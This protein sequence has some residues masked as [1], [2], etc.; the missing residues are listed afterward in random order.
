MYEFVVATDPK[1]LDQATPRSVELR[2][3]KSDVE[4]LLAAHWAKAKAAMTEAEWSG[5]R[6]GS[7]SYR[8]NWE[9]KKGGFVEAYRPVWA[10]LI[11]AAC[12]H[13]RTFLI[14]LSTV[15]VADRGD[16]YL[17]QS[18]LYT[19]P[20]VEFTEPMG[21][22]PVE[23]YEIHDTLIQR[24]VDARLEDVRLATATWNPVDQFPVIGNK[25]RLTI[26]AS[27]DGAPAPDWCITNQEF[28]LANGKLHPDMLVQ[29][30]VGKAVGVSFPFECVL[31]PI[32][33]DFAG[34]KYEAIVT[35]VQV[36]ARED[37]ADPLLAKARGFD[38]FDEYVASIRSTVVA[39]MTENRENTRQHLAIH[40]LRSRA[41]YEPLPVIWI[42]T[43]ATRQWELVVN[44][45]RPKTETQVIEEQHLGSREAAIAR[46][47]QDIGDEFRDNLA[48]VS[49]GI[50]VGATDFALSFDDN[51][52]AV[53]AKMM[54]RV[55]VK[56]VVPLSAR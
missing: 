34:K 38:T 47:A 33:R 16:K 37:L 17:L 48:V 50:A 1:L 29:A 55:V 21:D 6:I 26:Q 25:V 51:V 11:D 52:V 5:F 20:K 54:D 22:I 9:K 8:P 35:I 7:D 30:I 36:F 44:S 24:T 10:H 53:R 45:L 2:L 49:W 14:H 12:R 39:E 23:L 18:M 56:E 27:L 31:P 40:H 3:S 41:K 15:A 43:Q 42:K 19:A 4:P 28:V 46:L 13:N 32:Y